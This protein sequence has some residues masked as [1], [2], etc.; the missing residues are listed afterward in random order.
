M[1]D[2]LCDSFIRRNQKLY[3]SKFEASEHLR[4]F[5]QTVVSV[6]SVDLKKETFWQATAQSTIRERC[7]AIFN[8]ELL[9]DVKFMVQDSQGVSK[10]IPAHKFVLAISSP[11]FHA[12]FY[13]ELGEAK[14]FV[15][16]SDCKFE[17]L[18]ELLRF[19][20][21][22]EAN[23][24][25]NNVMELLY[26]AKKYMLP[27]LADKCSAYLQENLDT[28]NVFYVLPDARKYEEKD[29]VDHCWKVIE[30]ERKKQTKL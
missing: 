2:S 15:E 18:L 22:D 26:L 30:K 17:N 28:S 27:S 20:Y 9:S 7:Q 19:T 4:S 8:Q 6:M 29:L 11:V 1:H 23:L 21:S 14:D 12:M 3:C 24:S 16:I 13:G 10:T 5:N 25:L